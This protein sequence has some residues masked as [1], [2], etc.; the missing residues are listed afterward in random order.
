MRRTDDDDQREEKQEKRCRV[1]RKL[2][3]IK[4]LGA[5]NSF[6]SVGAV[7]FQSRELAGYMIGF[8]KL[9]AGVADWYCF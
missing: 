2:K 6:R 7:L 8:G 9:E 5:H 1:R 3:S 4:K